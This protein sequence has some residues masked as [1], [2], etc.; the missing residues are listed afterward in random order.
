MLKVEQ[1]DRRALPDIVVERF[2]T[3]MKSG[4]LKPGEQLPT[5]TELARDLGIGRTSL[6]EAIQRLRTMGAVEVRAG[7]GTFV[8]DR[9]RMEPVH[10]FVQ[11]SADNDFEVTELFEARMSLEVTAAGLAAERATT[12][13][14]ALLDRAA[15]KHRAAEHLES[16]IDSDEGFHE[17]LV[18][19]AH[20][21]LLSKLYA[22]LVPGLREFRSMSLAIPA[23]ATTSADTH[24]AIVAAIVAGDPTAAREATVEHLWGLYSMITSAANANSPDGTPRRQI[25]DKAVWCG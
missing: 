18:A 7:L 20:S 11:W 16:R 9:T 15:R 22:I 21:A 17:V 13:E 23:S 8:V 5:E 4:E 10:S 25:A 12:R 1:R 2:L 3:A 14:L 6:R 19:C 24:D